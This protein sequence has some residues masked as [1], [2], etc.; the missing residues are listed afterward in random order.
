[1]ERPSSYTHLQKS[2]VIK[3]QVWPDLSHW[4]RG[5]LIFFFTFLPIPLGSVILAKGHQ[6]DSGE[7]HKRQIQVQTIEQRSC[8]FKPGSMSESFGSITSS[9]V[10]GCRQLCLSP[11][12]RLF[13]LAGKVPSKGKGKES[14]GLFICTTTNLPKANPYAK[15]ETAPDLCNKGKGTTGFSFNSQQKAYPNSLQ[16]TQPLTWGLRIHPTLFSHFEKYLKNQSRRQC[17]HPL[18]ERTDHSPNQVMEQALKTK[19]VETTFINNFS[20]L[21]QKTHLQVW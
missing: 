6:R 11:K 17:K 10:N 18:Y 19:K 2:E 20:C 7:T 15:N 13:R 21:G 16:S 1:M 9:S 4:K 5:F 3:F 14:H 12:A 8:P